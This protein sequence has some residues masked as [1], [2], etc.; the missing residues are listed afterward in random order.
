MTGNNL[1]TIMPGMM[2]DC[3][4]LVE[5]SQGTDGQFGEKTTYAPGAAFK[6][7]LRKDQSPEVRVAEAQGVEEQYTVVVET[8]V[9]L[10]YGDV[11]RRDADGAVFRV[12]SNIADS[13]APAA[14]TVQIGAVRAKRWV[15][16][17]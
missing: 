10:K 2:T 16:P 4:M 12:T 11:F 8:G 15:L 14:S 1:G 5:E 6:A 7:L 9:M 3:T 17:T 13:T